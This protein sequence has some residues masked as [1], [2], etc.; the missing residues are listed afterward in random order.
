MDGQAG[1]QINSLYIFLKKV[2]KNRKKKSSDLQK[3]R[4]L[5]KN[6]IAKK[7]IQNL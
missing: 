7:N 4:L 1:R 2:Y 3:E 6:I 5:S